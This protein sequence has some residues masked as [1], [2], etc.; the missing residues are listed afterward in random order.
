MPQYGKLDN[1][2]LK[3]ETIRVRKVWASRK[4]GAG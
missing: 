3:W 1:R 4:Q 2:T